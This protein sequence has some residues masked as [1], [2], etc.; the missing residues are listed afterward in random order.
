MLTLTLTLNVT[1]A[2]LDRG[3]IRK[4]DVVRLHGDDAGAPS[5]VPLTL[6]CSPSSTC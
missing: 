1:I 6:T 4:E 2:C 3:L 5:H